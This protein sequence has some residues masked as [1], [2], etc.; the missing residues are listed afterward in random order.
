MLVRTIQVF[1]EMVTYNI[2]EFTNVDSK[3][4]MITNRGVPRGFPRAL[5]LMS[6]LSQNLRVKDQHTLIEQ[7]YVVHLFLKLQLATQF[8][9]HEYNSL[10]YDLKASKI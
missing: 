2:V 9:L 8:H 3:K 4:R 1:A 10:K 5:L 6:L 7:L